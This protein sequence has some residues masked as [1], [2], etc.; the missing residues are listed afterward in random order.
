MDVNFLIS[1][2]LSLFKSSFIGSSYNLAKTKP[3]D[4]KY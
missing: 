1:D 3:G 2:F 4:T